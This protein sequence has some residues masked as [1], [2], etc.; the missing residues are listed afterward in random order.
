MLRHSI[1][2]SPNLGK[3]LLNVNLLKHYLEENSNKQL[4]VLCRLVNCDE[5]SGAAA[6][7]GAA[8]PARG[9][10]LQTKVLE[11]FTITEIDSVLNVKALVGDFNQEKGLVG[12]FST[13][14]KTGWETDG[15]L[16]STK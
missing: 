9:Q 8:P 10:E 1:V 13:I 14:V 2:A 5:R 3:R 7:H 11:Y 16:H 12:A 6:G 15:P 4:L